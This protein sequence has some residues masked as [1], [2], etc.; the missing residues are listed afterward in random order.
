MRVLPHFNLSWEVH[1]ILFS[2]EIFIS[3]S[4]ELI[5]SVTLPVSEVKFLEMK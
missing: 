3:N 2:A 5:L 4:G 1:S